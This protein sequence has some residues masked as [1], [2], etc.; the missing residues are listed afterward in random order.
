MASFIDLP[1]IAR[2]AGV[3][4]GALGVLILMA[5]V[6]VRASTASYKRDVSE[7]RERIR[8]ELQLT[9]SPDGGVELTLPEH[10]TAASKD[11]DEGAEQDQTGPTTHNTTYNINFERGA[12]EERRAERE[13][14]TFAVLLADYYAHGLAQAQRSSFVSLA[15]SGFGCLMLFVGVGLAIWRSETTGGL[16]ATMVTNVTGIVTGVV[17]VLFHRQARR[18][19]EHLEGQTRLLRQDMR[20]E[21]GVRQATRLVE[22]V[23]DPALKAQL[24]AALVLQFAEASLPDVQISMP[25]R[26]AETPSHQHGQRVTP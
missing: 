11:G 8:R 7:N 1:N 2:I 6:A 15:F 12:V 25:R 10:P 21:R 18:A 22:E 16:Y 20:S 13:E 24:Q 9:A 19:L 26:R 3:L 23:E 5:L 4:V 14:Q 17:G